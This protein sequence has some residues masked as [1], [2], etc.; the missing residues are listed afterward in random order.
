M[1]AIEEKGKVKFYS[2][3]PKVYNNDFAF[4]LRSAEH[5]K[6]VGF[7][8][9]VQP[10]L[11]DT[12]KRGEIYFD[13]ANEVYTY[14]IVDKTTEGLAAEAAAKKQI[15]AEKIKEVKL[16]AYVESQLTPIER[17]NYYPEWVPGTYKIDVIRTYKGKV[18]KNTVEGNTNA[19]DKGGWIEVK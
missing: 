1:Y 5:H 2:S 18:F 9:V 19:P 17:L 11:T 8:P 12:Q 13:E 4:S 16:K 3:I 14:S 15:E 10:T 7:Y 6:S